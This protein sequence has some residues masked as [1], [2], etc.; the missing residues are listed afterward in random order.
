MEVNKIY[1]GD[2]IEVMKTLPD[3]SIDSIV[4]DPP[5]GLEFMGKEWDKLW[6]KNTL[7]VKPSGS[8]SPR[9]VDNWTNYKCLKCGHWINSG[10]PC[11]CKHPILEKR[12]PK[13]NQFKL[14]QQFHNQWATECLRILKPGGFLLSFGGTRTY[15]RMACGIEDA[16]FEI[17]DC[18][19]WLYG[20]GFPKSLNIGKQIDKMNYKYNEDF[21]KFGEYVKL[22]R[23]KKGLS[24]KD[25]EKKLG[26]N[27][28]LAWWEG[29]K[30]LG[31]FIVQLPD[32]KHYQELKELLDMDN[33]FDKLVVWLEAEREVIG[34]KES[35]C[36]NSEEKDRHTIG[37]SKN[38]EVNITIP[39]TPEA[40]QWEGWGTALKPAN[41]P[42]V[43][44]RKPLSEK[45]V[46]L[47][48]LKHGTA[49]LN[50][51]ACRIGTDDNLQREAMGIESIQRKN[52]EQGYSPKNYLE[53]SNKIISGGT[54]GRFPA[55]VIL[56][57]EAGRLID[58]QSGNVGGDS[59]TSKPTY[60]KGFW[61][62]ADSKESNSL[63]ND[64]GGAS[65]FFY[66][67]KSS[68]SERNLGG[69]KNIHPTVKSLKLMQ[70]LVRLVT[71]PKGTVL[72]PFIGS[73]TTAM[74]AKKEGF[75]YIGIEQ[76]AD[77]CKIAEARIKAIPNQTKLNDLNQEIE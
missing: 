75:N 68:K 11:H 71:P 37:S 38:I 8:Q 70:Y 43:V 26:T 36:F 72:D 29:R 53:G 39:A 58:E 76:D 51:D 10:T 32:K 41:E 46:A 59:R 12:K 54:Q 34:K 63:Y 49:G 50:I 25:V 33:R 16:G 1:Q 9:F 18:I 73:G 24:R 66:C 42:I 57:E 6:G 47:N 48:V 19:Q 14:M 62:N 52:A 22:C 35:A 77:Y 55:N 7:G 20:S 30:Y 15:H 17:R 21:T 5:Y 40:K 65:R 64:K 61:G 45:N 13:N 60:N 44:A 23:E 31:E 69:I 2:C 74:A 3:N 28:A 67:A 27:T 4:T 56:D